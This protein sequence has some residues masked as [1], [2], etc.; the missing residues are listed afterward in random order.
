MDGPWGLFGTGPLATVQPCKEDL[1][2]EH[3]PPFPPPPRP[4]DAQKESSSD[5][6]DCASGFLVNPT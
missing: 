6:Q 5:G 1:E 3:P 4:P 2:A